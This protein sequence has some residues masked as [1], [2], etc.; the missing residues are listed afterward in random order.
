MTA[1][2][3]HRGA[4]CLALQ[5]ERVRTVLGEML[6]VTDEQAA[7][8]AVDWLDF[9]ARMHRL[10]QLH[11]GTGNYRLVESHA[12]TA[13][14]HGLERYF[15]GQLDAIDEIAVETGGTPFQ[16]K[17]WSA[18]RRIPTGTTTSYGLLAASVDRPKAIRAAGAAN[19]AN[20]IGIVIP[21]HRVIGADSAL[22]GY[23]GGL[24]RK[25]WLLRHEGVL[26]PA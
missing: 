22:T 20:P 12:Q 1:I 6:V 3:K 4:S 10:L 9:E 26:L 14:R 16:R 7:L 25:R 21:C 2:R 24:E 23:G 15:A 17:I 18:L 11:Y 19:G 5:V 8:R 13:A